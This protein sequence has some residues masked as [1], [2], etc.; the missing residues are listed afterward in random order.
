M[1][2]QKLDTFELKDQFN[3]PH[4]EIVEAAVGAAVRRADMAG[5]GECCIVHRPDLVYL[6]GDFKIHTF[7][8]W[9]DPRIEETA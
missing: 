6:E 7:E 4:G 1:M 9:G 5:W 3:L 8:I 2:K